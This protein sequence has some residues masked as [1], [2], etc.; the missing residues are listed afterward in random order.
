[1]RL[2]PLLEEEERPELCFYIH[3]VQ[4]QPEGGSL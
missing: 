1:M 3:D 4:T 2:A